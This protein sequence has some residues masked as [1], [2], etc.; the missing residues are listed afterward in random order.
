MNSA[1]GSVSEHA[2][3]LGTLVGPVLLLTFWATWS[4]LR[5]WMGR[6]DQVVVPT[7]ALVAAALS[8][9]AA[10]IHAIVIPP[11]LTESVMYGV[12]FAGVAIGQLAW[13]VLVVVRPSRWVL[14]AGGAA[15]LAVVALWAVTRTVGIPLGAAAGRREAVGVLDVTCGLLELGVVGCCAWLASTRT[16]AAPAEP[17]DVRRWTGD[18]AGQAATAASHAWRGHGSGSAQR[19]PLLGGQGH[20]DPAAHGRIPAQDRGRTTSP[21]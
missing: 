6:Q 2:A 20:L 12:F 15:N 8:V 1:A 14:A 13:A 4:E 16:L 5:A 18:G 3:H 17:R 9:G 21:A 7:A 19:L 10:V 11:H